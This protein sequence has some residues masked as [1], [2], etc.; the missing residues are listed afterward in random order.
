MKHF[1]V[2]QWRSMTFQKKHA[3]MIEDIISFD[4]VI[5]YQATKQLTLLNVIILQ[6][7]LPSPEH[8]TVHTSQPRT[9]GYYVNSEVGLMTLRQKHKYCRT[10][11]NQLT[12]KQMHSLLS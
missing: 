12:K 1:Y 2:I 5:G 9:I 6:R 10:K 7:G 4:D 8:I 11:L 3:S